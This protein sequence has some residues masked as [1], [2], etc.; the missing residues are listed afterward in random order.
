MTLD[1]ALRNFNFVLQKLTRAPVLHNQHDAVVKFLFL[2]IMN[3]SHFSQNVI[4]SSVSISLF[5]SSQIVRT[6]FP[7]SFSDPGF[8]KI[9]VD[10]L[11]NRE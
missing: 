2:F 7:L 9:M 5:F 1:Q 3:D 10:H 4:L 6:F 8:F 11:E